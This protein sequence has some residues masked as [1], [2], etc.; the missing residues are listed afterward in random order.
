[1]PADYDPGSSSSSA[2]EV[3]SSAGGG[4]GGKD[5]PAQWSQKLIRVASPIAAALEGF[6]G[7]GTGSRLAPQL[8]ACGN[9]ESFEAVTRHLLLVEPA[10]L[11]ARDAAIGY[12]S[13]F[14]TTTHKA[15]P[16]FAKW[17]LH[18]EGSQRGTFEYVFQLDVI[19]A[20]SN[21][22]S[23]S[24]CANSPGFPSHHTYDCMQTDTKQALPNR[25][26]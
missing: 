25:A 24:L 3:P 7:I 21:T 16:L 6:G 20:Y 1:M 19:L 10:L 15:K 2:A 14:E 23:M 17:K 5:E 9:G 18:P 11:H 22:Y 26:S 8:V 4:G 13:S 12:F